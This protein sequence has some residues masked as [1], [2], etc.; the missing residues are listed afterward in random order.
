[1]EIIFKN[2]NSRD[3]IFYRLNEKVLKSSFKVQKTERL[4]LINYNDLI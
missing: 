4:K 3:E 2:K 1:M